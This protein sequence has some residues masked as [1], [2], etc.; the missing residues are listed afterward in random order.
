MVTAMP[1]LAALLLFTASALAL[2]GG[3]RRTS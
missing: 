2:V 1:E 3:R